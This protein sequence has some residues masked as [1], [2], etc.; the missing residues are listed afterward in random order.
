MAQAVVGRPRLVVVDDYYQNVEPD[1]RDHL[2][3]TLT[4]PREPWPP[5]RLS[6]APAFA[7]ARHP[8]AAAPPPAG[9][10][11]PRRAGAPAAREPRPALPG[12]LRPR[13]RARGRARGA[14]RAL[15]AR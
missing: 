8:R 2:V 14:R 11:P 9:P 12:R 5:A 13:A 6:Q 7:A 10:A 4:D 1:C 3:Q 15:G